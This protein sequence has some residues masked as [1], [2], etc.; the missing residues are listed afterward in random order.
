MKFKFYARMLKINYEIALG[1][2]V[3]MKKVEKP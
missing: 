1:K 3:L 2:W